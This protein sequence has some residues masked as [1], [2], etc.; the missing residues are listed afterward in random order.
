MIRIPDFFYE[1]YSETFIKFIHE[2]HNE[3]TE[4][5]TILPEHLIIDQYQDIFFQMTETFYPIIDD[6]TIEEYYNNIKQF[7]NFL[8]KFKQL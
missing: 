2:I 3:I 7:S 8:K 1:I 5:K 4:I 6:E